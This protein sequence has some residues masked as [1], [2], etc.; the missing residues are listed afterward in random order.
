DGY[1]GPGGGVPL[2]LLWEL[3][4]AHPGVILL[5][6]A[7]LGFLYFRYGSLPNASRTQR[8]FEERDAIAQLR[9]TSMDIAGWVNAL[10]LKDPS[11]PLEPLLG[12]VQALFV[13]AQEA[14]FKR[15]L[16]PLRPFVSDSVYQ[17]LSA[18]LGLLARQGVRNGL[19]EVR[20][21]E[22]QP[23]GLE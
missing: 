18:Q 8:A 12:R 16:R 14:W 6:V 21:L 17:R 4:Y 1:T 10:R 20:I 3:A 15:E 5:L 2:W 9:A 11:F 19:D 22:T 7:A 13:Q 23:A